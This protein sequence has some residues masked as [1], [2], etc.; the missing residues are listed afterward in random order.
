MS[1][2]GPPGDSSE[3]LHQLGS[4][5]PM[6]AKRLLPALEMHGIP[7]EIET[8]NSALAHPNRWMG[9]A[10]GLYPDGSKIVVFVP[11]SEMARALDVLHG[12]FPA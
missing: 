5:E 11:E 7:F 2:D 1:I 9:L 6:E 4:F 3:M 12:L 10:F 8:D